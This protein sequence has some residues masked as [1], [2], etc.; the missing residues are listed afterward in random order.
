MQA[1]ALD[2][3]LTPLPANNRP[4]IDWPLIERRIRQGDSAYSIEQDMR[5]AKT[6]VSRVSII[7]RAKREGWFDEGRRNQL[8]ASFR[9]QPQRGAKET[10][11]RKLDILDSIRSGLSQKLACMKAGI[12]E[13]TV[14]RWKDEDKAFQ[15]GYEQAIA[16]WA[17]A[18]IGNIEKAGNRGDW[19]ADSYLLERNPATRAEFAQ[20]QNHSGPSIQVVLSIPRTAE[21]EPIT[22]ESQAVELIEAGK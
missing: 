11:E 17:E 4:G 18:R 13:A 10:P 22:I 20:T 21:A 1:A 12:T 2:G 15:A 8:T 14:I 19:K 3:W 5:E 6:P 9:K 16:D 7:K